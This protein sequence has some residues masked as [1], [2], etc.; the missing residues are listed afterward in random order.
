MRSAAALSRLSE[1]VVSVDPL[2]LG[3]LASGM[4]G[5]P[6]AE[7]VEAFVLTSSG[8]GRILVARAASA[9]AARPDVDQLIAQLGASTDDLWKATAELLSAI[10]DGP[11]CELGWGLD[12]RPDMD[13]ACRG[14]W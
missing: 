11:G 9:L 2:V 1:L 13:C 6:F 8:A 14:T 5:G 4:A 7:L 10:L 12:C 3:R